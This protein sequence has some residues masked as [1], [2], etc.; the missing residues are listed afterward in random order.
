ME[1]P[2]GTPSGSGAAAK[3]AAA[4][5]AADKDH[6]VHNG[7]PEPMDTGECGSLGREGGGYVMGQVG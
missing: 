2:A 4:W 5:E 7:G 3:Q 6:R 1:L